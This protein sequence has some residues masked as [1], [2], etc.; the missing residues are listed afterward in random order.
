MS[1]MEVDGLI[2]VQRE[3]MPG[4]YEE[5]QVQP[6]VNKLLTDGR[7]LNE[8]HEEFIQKPQEAQEL[9]PYSGDLQVAVGDMN[10]YVK[11]L[12]ERVLRDEEL[13]QEA[14][15]TLATNLAM[16]KNIL[17]QQNSYLLQYGQV[18]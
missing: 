8:L 2:A 17:K 1:S 18:A 6:W 11:D 4:N 15:I 9:V 3:A 14:F 5:K 12:A 10:N 16:V 7:E 13:S